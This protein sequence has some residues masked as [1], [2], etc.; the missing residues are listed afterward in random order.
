MKINSVKAVVNV[1][2]HFTLLITHIR[3]DWIMLSAQTKHP[4]AGLLEFTEAEVFHLG[5]NKVATHH[6]G[7]ISQR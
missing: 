1:H 3:R 7:Q 4:E 5:L 2:L 6:F